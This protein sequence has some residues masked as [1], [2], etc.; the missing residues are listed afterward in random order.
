MSERERQ[1]LLNRT[2]NKIVDRRLLDIS[3]DIEQI[4]EKHCTYAFQA[5]E[6]LPRS[7]RRLWNII[8]LIYHADAKTATLQPVY[9]SNISSAIRNKIGIISYSLYINR[10]KSIAKRI[11]R[12]F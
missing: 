7:C 12:L 10:N 4:S 9:K 3:W 11:D 6:F 2:P 1:L 8:V 5:I